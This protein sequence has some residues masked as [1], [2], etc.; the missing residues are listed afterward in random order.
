MTPVREAV[1]RLVAE[2]ALIDTPSRTLQVPPFDR[3][4]LMTC[5]APASRSSPC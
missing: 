1:R 5:C 4:R 3:A 2:G